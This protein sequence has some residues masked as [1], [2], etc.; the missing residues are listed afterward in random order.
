VSDVV[1]VWHLKVRWLHEFPD[2]PVEIYS[3]IGEDG[4]EQRKVEIFRDGREHVADAS[5]STDGTELSDQPVVFDEIAA[6]GELEPTRITAAEFESVWR[7]AT[8]A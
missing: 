5:T 6:P 2:L 3:E 1:Q 4:Y 8:G 7:A